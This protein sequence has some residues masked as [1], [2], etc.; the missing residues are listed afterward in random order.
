MQIKTTK[1]NA[2][3]EYYKGTYATKSK[4]KNLIIDIVGIITLLVVIFLLVVFVA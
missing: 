3:F 2:P 1:H 4:A